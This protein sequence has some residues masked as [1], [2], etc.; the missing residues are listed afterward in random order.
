MTPYLISERHFRPF[1]LEAF[2]LVTK[3]VTFIPN[4]VGADPW[5]CHEVTRAIAKML[6]KRTMRQW[7][8][9]DGYYGACEHTWLMTPE[10]KRGIILDCYAV[11][12][13]PMVQLVD[14]SG[15]TIESA[16]YQPDLFGGREPEF[17]DDIDFKVVDFLFGRID[18]AIEFPPIHRVSGDAT[19]D[20]CGSPYREHPSD[21]KNTDNEGH[22]FLRVACDGRRVKL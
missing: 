20:E 6:H 7:R 5:R 14:V 21:R 1:E 19:C 13:L 10:D 4:P 15:P 8:L 16:A 9:Y 11:G 17:R 3:W 22:P 18:D 12:R 2:E